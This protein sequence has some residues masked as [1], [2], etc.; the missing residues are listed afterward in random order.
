MELNKSNQI[1]KFF[2]AIGMLAISIFIYRSLYFGV[3]PIIP[4]QS[5]NEVNFDE[6]KQNTL[7]IF[8]TDNTL[9]QPSDAYLVNEH[10]P[11]EIEFRKKLFIDNPQVKDWD[12]LGSIVLLQAQRPLIEPIVISKINSLKNR[13]IPVIVL[14][15]M[16]TG[17]YGNSP[18]SLVPSMEKWRYEQLKSLGFEGSFQDIDFKFDSFKHKP[19]FYKGITASDTEDK[20]PVLGA[21]LDKIKLHPQEIVMFDDTIGDLESV[22]AEAEKR[23]IK[24]KGYLY[25]GAITKPW[26]EKLFKFQSDYLIKHHQWLSDEQAQKLMQ[27]SSL[28]NP[29]YAS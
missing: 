27:E 10:T 17:R 26:N 14:T 6:I 15:G 28:S 8:D 25:Q 2:V 9:I 4:I 22:K 29:S 20:G 5:F 12:L 19:V 3:K 11:Q 18:A 16:N 13:N 24:F 21:F 1:F 23:N 7:V